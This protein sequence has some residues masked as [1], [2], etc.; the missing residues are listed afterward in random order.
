MFLLAMMIQ[1]DVYICYVTS[2]NVRLCKNWQSYANNVKI[3][4]IEK[5]KIIMKVHNKVI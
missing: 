4:S 2:V 5:M 1:I 3:Q